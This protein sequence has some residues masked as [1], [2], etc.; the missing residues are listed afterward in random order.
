MSNKLIINFAPTGMI[1][2]KEMTPHVPVSVTEI[3][4]DVHEACE[5][6]ISMVHL[7]ARDPLSG[8]PMIKRDFR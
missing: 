5:L 2:T 6:G 4:E 7:H 1:P 8:K 3:V